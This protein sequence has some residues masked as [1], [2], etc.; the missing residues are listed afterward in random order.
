MPSCPKLEKGSSATSDATTSSGTA[1]L[2]AAGGAIVIWL[3]GVQMKFFAYLG[4]LFL[5]SAPI[6]ISFLISTS[7]AFV[8]V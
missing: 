5:F 7:M 8:P 3:A 2:I 1:F 6:A 4:A